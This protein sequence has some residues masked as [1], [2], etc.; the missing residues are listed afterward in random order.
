MEAILAIV[1]IVLALVVIAKQ[2]KP[3]PVS[4]LP[5]PSDDVRG[6]IGQGKK[7]AAIRAYRK[8]TGAT[9]LEANHVVGRY[10]A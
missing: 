9:L 3:R 2:P 10:A 8:Q 7:V 6:L 4:D 5:V 1:V